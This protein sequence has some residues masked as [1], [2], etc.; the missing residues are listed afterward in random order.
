M[1]RIT[2]RLQEEREA[3]ETRRKKI[4][5]RD[6][7]FILESRV[8]ELNEKLAQAQKQLCEQQEASERLIRQMAMKRDE[9]R[10][11]LSQ[12]E[13]KDRR[14]EGN[15]V[16][17]HERLSSQ[18]AA[19][20]LLINKLEAERDESRTQLSEAE[21]RAQKLQEILKQEKQQAEARA[22]SLEQGLATIR[23]TLRQEKEAAEV[24]AHQLKAEQDESRTQLSGFESHLQKLEDKLALAQRQFQDLREAATRRRAGE[25]LAEREKNKGGKPNPLHR[26]RAIP[27]LKDDGITEVQ[28]H[29]EKGT[30]VVSQTTPEGRR[31]FIHHYDEAARSHRWVCDL[32]NWERKH[33]VVPKDQAKPIDSTEDSYNKEFYK[34]V[35][36]EHRDTQSN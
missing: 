25:I 11:Q 31:W 18:I 29:R 19:S 26:A 12:S 9:S 30:Q 2:G 13:A 21:A 8:S 5:E 23:Q 22:T 27:R 1:F 36:A 28:S 6:L 33:I 16:K 17:A 7:H 10:S 24:L 32:C 14:L 4:Q 35:C 15:L 34:H 3:E 20:H